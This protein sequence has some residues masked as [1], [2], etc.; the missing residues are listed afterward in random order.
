MKLSTKTNLTR[1]IPAFGGVSLENSFMLNNNRTVADA[2]P[3]LGAIISVIL[4]NILII[5]SVI[6][7][8]IIVFA[9]FKVVSSGGNAEKA[10]EGKQAL[11]G[12]IIGF[13]IIFASFWII[14][15]I[16]I[17]TGINILNNPLTTGGA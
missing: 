8:F 12:A 16:Q 1:F 14:Q 10:A 4:P 9:G 11:T 6:L 7:L 17:I 3:S 15:A 13:I 2:F 5:S